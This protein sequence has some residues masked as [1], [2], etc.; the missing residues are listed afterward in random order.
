MCCIP[1]EPGVWDEICA[2]EDAAKVTA[3]TWTFSEEVKQAKGLQHAEPST[4]G[5]LRL[6][7]DRFC[8]LIWM[9]FGSECNYYEALMELRLILMA[10]TIQ[11]LQMQFTPYTIRSYF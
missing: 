10:D 5:E 3:T 1:Y 4:H 6:A 9:L 7:L 8:A 11:R 2:K